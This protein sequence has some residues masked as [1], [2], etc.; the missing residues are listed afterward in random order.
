MELHAIVPN[1]AV[2]V[3]SIMK[4]GT[5]PFWG[6]LGVLR[7]PGCAGRPSSTRIRGSSLV[8]STS[9][10]L[11]P[12][13]ATQSAAP[14]PAQTLRSCSTVNRACESVKSPRCR[15]LDP[16]NRLDAELWIRRIASMQNFGSVESPSFGTAFL[17]CSVARSAFLAGEV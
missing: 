10:S 7:F 13:G 5:E 2:Q 12:I 11:L 9:C 6:L 8:S 17:N 4:K 1:F 3:V 16:S 15:T 14:D